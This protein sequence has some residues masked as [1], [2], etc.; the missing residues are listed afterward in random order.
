MSLAK[1]IRSREPLFQ[2][3]PYD[4]IGVNDVFYDNHTKDPKGWEPIS[5]VHFRSFRAKEVFLN[6]RRENI[7]YGWY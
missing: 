1:L 5:T 7:K 4:T 6:E 2:H 3:I